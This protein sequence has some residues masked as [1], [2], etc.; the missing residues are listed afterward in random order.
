MSLVITR[1]NRRL[2]P[3]IAIKKMGY[4]GREVG[5]FLLMRSYSAIRMSEEGEKILG[6]RE[7]LWEFV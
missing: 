4:S 6:K 1:A 5:R 7:F 2:D 3:L